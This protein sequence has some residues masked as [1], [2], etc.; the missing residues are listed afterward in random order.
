[1]ELLGDT[2]VVLV[3]VVISR[4]V[5]ALVVVFVAIVVEIVG[6][7]LSVA[8][9]ADEKDELN[10]DELAFVHEIIDKK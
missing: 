4:I 8:N 3:A 7:R 1:V 2:M 9:Q 5:S 6:L 10:G